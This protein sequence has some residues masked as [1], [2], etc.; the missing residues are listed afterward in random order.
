M[1][2][3]RL[4]SVEAKYKVADIINSL[5]KFRDEHV[6]DYEK[7]IVEYQKKLVSRLEKALKVAQSGKRPQINAG[8]SLAVPSNKE[9]E[10]NHIINL[11][12]TTGDVEIAL[13]FAEAD[14]IFNDNWDWIRSAKAVNYGYTLGNSASAECF[15]NEVDTEVS[16]ED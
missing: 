2:G 15:F 11:F 16:I 9:K 3:N 4:T 13:S 6:K 7:A 5:S 8:L 14:S 12:K 10:Y 1:I